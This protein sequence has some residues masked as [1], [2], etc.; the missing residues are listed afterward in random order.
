MATATTTVTATPTAAAMTPADVKAMLAGVRPASEP[1]KVEDGTRIHVRY[2]RMV[3]A[4]VTD[5][6]K[7]EA[8]RAKV[9][10]L[11]LDTY[12][13]RVS[14]VWT[15]KA[16]D[17]ILSLFVELERDHTWRSFNIDH[18]TIIHLVILGN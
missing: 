12:T 7:A 16:G 8:D 4:K 1:G 13:G 2:T 9:L 10:G 5:R 3:G 11:P 14:R 15:S 17:T 6:A 18:G